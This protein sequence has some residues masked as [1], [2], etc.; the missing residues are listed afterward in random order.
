M[1]IPTIL[2]RFALRG[3]ASQLGEAAVVVSTHD[4]RLNHVPARAAM[5]SRG[6]SET[7]VF[8]TAKGGGDEVAMRK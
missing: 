2:H 8:N 1:H 7:F 3:H 4:S 6:D 5:P